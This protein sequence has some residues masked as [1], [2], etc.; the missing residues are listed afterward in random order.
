M[1]I[2]YTLHKMC[3]CYAHVFDQ[4]ITFIFPYTRVWVTFIIFFQK[5][6]VCVA[7]KPIC[8]W[9]KNVFHSLK[10]RLKTLRERGAWGKRILN[11]IFWRNVSRGCVCVQY[12]TCVCFLLS[13][14]F[15]QCARVCLWNR[16]NEGKET[17][18]KTLYLCASLCDLNCTAGIRLVCKRKSWFYP[19]I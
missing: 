1:Y 17:K 18:Y 10:W 15:C 4:N 12:L 6:S 14:S 16:L 5:M 19:S 2:L 13:L 3:M 11:D 9:K 7:C 8:V